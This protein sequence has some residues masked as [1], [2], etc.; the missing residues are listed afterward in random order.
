VLGRVGDEDDAHV[1][2]GGQEAG[3]QADAPKDPL[4][5]PESTDL[6]RIRLRLPD[7]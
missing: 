4:K 2:E 5:G 3:E 6:G 7:M 1:V